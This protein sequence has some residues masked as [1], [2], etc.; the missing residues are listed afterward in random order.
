LCSDKKTNPNTTGSWDS[1]KES[2][3]L[4]E[5]VR[6]HRPGSTKST[7]TTYQR[8]YVKY[9]YENKIPVEKQ[10]DPVVIAK[11]LKD[12]FE[13]RGL[14]RST[15]T[16]VMPAAIADLSRYEKSKP[17]LSDIVKEV[18]KTI[19]RLTKPGKGKAPLPRHLLVRMTDM[20]S[21]TEPELKMVRDIF[22]FILMFG[23]FMRQ[24]EVTALKKEDV[25]IGE[26]EGSE[27]PCVYIFIEKSKTDQE[28]T[29]ETIVLQAGNTRSKLCPVTWYKI[30]KALKE[31]D[32]VDF[33]Y[34]VVKGHKK[35]SA[36]RPNNLLKDFLKEMGL[37]E[38]EREAY[39]SHSLRKG[40]ATRAAS[41]KI[42]THVIKRHGRWRSDAVYIYIIDPV[43]A[44]LQVS[45]AVL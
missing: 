18:K 34:S 10:R 9:C 31:K 24:S 14:S 20:V 27:G 25:W 19:V 44:R 11:F 17:T 6:K 3:A 29:G 21:R 42:R 13:T 40:G 23:G 28:R 38:K 16:V 37:E 32:T 26:E 35:L 36:G 33:F 5:W 1:E 39:G 22:M 4:Q 15:L 43:G 45:K 7:Y 12:Q 8:Q 41:A 2:E 30:Y